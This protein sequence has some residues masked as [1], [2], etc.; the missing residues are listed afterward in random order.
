MENNQISEITS[1]KKLLKIIKQIIESDEN[2]KKEYISLNSVVNIL[3]IDKYKYEELLSNGVERLEYYTYLE[4]KSLKLN[5]YELIFSLII[6]NENQKFRF[7]RK[8]DDW[9]VDFKNSNHLAT[10]VSARIAPVTK[11]IEKECKNSFMFC[12]YLASHEIQEIETINNPLKI[13]LCKRG[14]VIEYGELLSLHFDIESNEFE[15]DY[16]S[17]SITSL[18]YNNEEILLNRLYVPINKFPSYIQPYL[19][20]IREDEL[21]KPKCIE[22][23][24]DNSMQKD[25]NQKQKKFR[26]F[27]NN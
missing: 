18:L 4:V 3:K 13:S 15:Y 26:F 2:E 6:N 20:Q 12:N 9:Y 5:Y 7:E 22:I 23:V 14:I 27:K 8:N 24:D 21:A 1:N 17:N 16:V 10:K 25:K 19:K 11:K